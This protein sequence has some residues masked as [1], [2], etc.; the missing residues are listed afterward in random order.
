MSFQVSLTDVMTSVSSPIRPFGNR[1]EVLLP[2]LRD[3]RSL[4]KAGPEQGSRNSIPPIETLHSRP[5][6][7]ENPDDEVDEL[8]DERDTVGIMP[9]CRCM[10][11]KSLAAAI[12]RYTGMVASFE[13]PEYWY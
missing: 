8:V 11:D 10:S 12:V 13:P 5:D 2:R 4:A 1:V 9:N 7:D 3:A 6:D